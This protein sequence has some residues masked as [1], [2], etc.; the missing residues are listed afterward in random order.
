MHR[1]IVVSAAIAALTAC[2]S[3]NQVTQ[4]CGHAEDGFDIEAV[5]VLQDAQGYPGMHDAVILDFDRT[6]LPA[7][8]SWRVKSV[9][10]LPMIT[11]A[12]F[13]GFVDG[14]QISVEIFDGD[15]PQAERY[16][17]TQ[18]F[19]KADLTWEDVTLTDSTTAWDPFQTSA[20]W[21]FDF[22]D[23]IPS[24]GLSGGKYLAGV[25][26]DTSAQPTLGYSNFNLACDKNW[27]DWADGLGWKH[28]AGQ[29]GNLECSWPMM[30]VELEVLQQ[31]VYCAEDSV[32]VEE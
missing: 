23:V 29:Y 18:T 4:L 16:V 7:D 12:A 8:A 26:W 32:I 5:S 25:V 28:N 24:S 17:V 14:Q 20:W 22:S 9:D 11:R 31:Q 30:R 13:H 21:T 3:E 2:S 6:A 27:T 19:Q 1:L 15:N 10:I